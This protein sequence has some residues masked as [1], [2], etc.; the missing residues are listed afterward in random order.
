MG[1]VKSLKKA[2]VMWGL[3]NKQSGVINAAFYSRSDAREI[4][5]ITDS[6][7]KLEVKEVK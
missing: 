3:K 6:V 5:I 2:Q 4:K 1:K 7:V